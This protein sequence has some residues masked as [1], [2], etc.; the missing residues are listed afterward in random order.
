MAFPKTR[1]SCTSLR[2]RDLAPPPRHELVPLVFNSLQPVLIS[3]PPPHT[4]TFGRT[5]HEFVPL[6]L[7]SLQPVLISLPPPTTH[8]PLPLLLL[9]F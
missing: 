7:N 6:V 4:H 8:T 3:L 2:P 9:C 1:R 5:R